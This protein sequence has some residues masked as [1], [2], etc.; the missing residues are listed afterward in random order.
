MS[1]ITHITNAGGGVV[2]ELSSETPLGAGNTFTSEW[3]NVDQYATIRIAVSADQDGA[4][5]A[6]HS[7]DGV[8]VMRDQVLLVESGTPQFAIVSPRTR[9]FR[10]TFVNTSAVGQTL[11]SLQTGLHMAPLEH[12]QT[13][14]S[15]PLTRTSLTGQTRAM[16]YDYRF[17]AHGTIL[18]TTKD[19]VITARQALLA[20]A[21]IGASLDTSTWASTL[22]GTGSADIVANTQLVMATGLTANSSSKVVSIPKGRFIA[23]NISGGSIGISLPDTGVAN[24]KRRWGTYDDDN[25]YFFELDGTTLYA[26]GRNAT[27]DTRTAAASW[28]RDTTFTVEANVPHVYETVFF[29]NVGYFLID[30]EV[31]HITSTDQG[32]K[33]HFP[34]RMENTNS[35]GSTTNVVMNVKGANLQRYGPNTVSPR[36]QRIS[37][38]STT[39]LKAGPG[40]LHRVIVANG[41]GANTATLYDNTAGSGTVITAL[42]VNKISGSIDF[43]TDLSTGLTIV[44]TGVDTDVTVVWD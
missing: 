12:T 39:V 20:D 32:R 9:F 29:G 15:A 21:F 23:G 36:F 14:V 44:T 27:V 26:V 5:H 19:L 16:L 17:D 1:R 8:T 35:G 25:G 10:V 34:I 43:G 33:G 28:S 41:S 31:V 37:G 18:P 7:V 4:L 6:Q 24:N 38:A 40:H 11:F 13:L 42:N 22:V 30:D 3:V 2:A